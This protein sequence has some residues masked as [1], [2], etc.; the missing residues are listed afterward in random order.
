MGASEIV[1]FRS[2]TGKGDI[3]LAKKVPLSVYAFISR[4]LLVLW[5]EAAPST[6]FDTHAFT[7][8]VAKEEKKKE[9]ENECG[10]STE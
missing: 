8:K 4:L 6:V 9:K 3:F 5:P 1:I 7:I 2:W 10:R